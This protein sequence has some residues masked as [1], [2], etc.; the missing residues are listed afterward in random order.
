MPKAAEKTTLK[1]GFNK[2]LTSERREIGKT[3][4]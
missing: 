1:Q 2:M 3:L 4:R